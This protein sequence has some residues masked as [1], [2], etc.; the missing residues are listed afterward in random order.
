MRTVDGNWNGGV[1]EATPAIWLL[2]DRSPDGITFEAYLKSAC[3]PLPNCLDVGAV[4]RIMPLDFEADVSTQGPLRFSPRNP[5]VPFLGR[6]A[7]LRAL[8]EFLTAK[9]R[10]PFSWWVIIGGGGAGKT[11]LAREICLRMR[12][13]GWR[14]GFLPSS[15]VAN[16]SSLDAWCPRTPTLIVADY[17]LKRTEEIR[18]LAARLARR[19]GLPPLRL[20]LLEREAGTLFENQFLGNDYSDRGVIE[21][22]RYQPEPL[23]YRS[24]PKTKSGLWSR[25]VH[26]DPTRPACRSLA[27]NSSDG[28]TNWTAS[29]GR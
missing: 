25:H 16:T 27:T 21:Q 13:R 6:E 5:R 9:G 24:S 10:H 2:S 22:A 18:K 17:V 26:G 4:D 7:A 19:D 12:R 11:R 8:D 29:T 20:L 28:W 14:A 3:L 1:L 23:S 15:F